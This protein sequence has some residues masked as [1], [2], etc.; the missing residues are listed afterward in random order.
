MKCSACQKELVGVGTALICPS[1]SGSWRYGE[2]IP[3]PIVPPTPDPHPPLG[4]KPEH[5]WVEDRI[6]DL[7]D[8]LYQARWSAGCNV[9]AIMPLANELHKCLGRYEC[10]RQRHELICGE[11]VTS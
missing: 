9:E 8:A 2:W 4:I 3:D 5:L 7:I 6:H 1:C 11:E 10:A